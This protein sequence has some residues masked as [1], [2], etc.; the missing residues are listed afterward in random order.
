[1]NALLA[2]L[3]GVV[4]G[5]T[6][7]L[8]ISSTGHLILVSRMLGLEGEGTKSFD[9]VIQLGAILAVLVHYRRLLGERAVGLASR[10][11]ESIALL[12]ALVVGFVPAGVVGLL[13]GKTIKHYLFGPGPVAVALVVGGLLMIGVETVRKRQA[14]S[15]LEGLE[16]V[17]PKRALLVGLGQCFALLPGASRSMC[18]IVAGQLTG[19]STAT[20]AEFSFLLGLPTLGAATVYEGFK[21]RA[22]LGGVGAS[23]VVIGLAVSFVVAWG[24]IAAFLA[25]LKRRGLMP[26]GFYRIVLGGAILLVMLRA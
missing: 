8:P 12:V 26:F 2:V 9:I 22:E 5:I 21:A 17:T 20:A 6:E 7:Y 10:K 13:L 1:V 14:S 4:E 11:P 15:G 23:N 3:L 24:V 18:T 19:L 16:H 25:Y